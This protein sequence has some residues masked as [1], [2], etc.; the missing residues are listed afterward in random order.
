MHKLME[1]F[2]SRRKKRLACVTVFVKGFYFIGLT[3]QLSTNLTK[4]Q[5]S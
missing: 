1:M 5:F 4:N 3:L 2:I